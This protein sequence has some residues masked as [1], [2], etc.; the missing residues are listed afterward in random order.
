LPTLEEQVSRL[1]TL[2]KQSVEYQRDTTAAITGI[3]SDIAALRG[4]VGELRVEV[5]ALRRETP[6][7]VDRVDLKIGLL[8][9]EVRANTARLEEL[10]RWA[11]DRER[12]GR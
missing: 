12:R 3:R 6:T 2:A 7:E 9:D 1:T 4:E 5:V 8:G 10:G 11:A